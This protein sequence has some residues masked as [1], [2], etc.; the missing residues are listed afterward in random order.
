MISEVIKREIIAIV[1]PDN[2]LDSALNR[3]GYSYDSSF[4]PLLPKNN[5]DLVVRPLT[6][7]EVSR[8][9]VVACAHEIPVTPRGAGSGRTG[10]SIPQKGGI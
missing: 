5:P 2:V 1:G 3:F 6:T 10:G 8:V 9:M 7:D 4:V